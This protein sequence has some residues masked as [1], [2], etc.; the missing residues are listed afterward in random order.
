MNWVA[1]AAIA[2]CLTLLSVLVG[3]GIM[4]GGMKEQVAG[5]TKGADSH[6]KEI[7]ALDGRVNSLDVE[8]GRLREWKDGYNAA[9]RVS[10]RTAE[11]RAADAAAG[12]G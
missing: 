5:L 11:F 12:R 8:V 6:G 9:A 7:E 4:W 10:G 3:G 1:V 2:S